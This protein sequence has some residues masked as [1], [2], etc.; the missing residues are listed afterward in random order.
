MER[1]KRPIIWGIKINLLINHNDND[2]DTRMFKETLYV[3]ETK[4]ECKKTNKLPPSL[5]EPFMA[6]CWSACNATRLSPG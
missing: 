6:D 4:A 5:Q 2:N 3:R 1:V